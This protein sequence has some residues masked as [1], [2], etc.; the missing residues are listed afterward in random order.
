MNLKSIVGV[1]GGK[2]W[3]GSAK[4]GGGQPTAEHTLAE[5]FKGA[6]DMDVSDMVRLIW[7]GGWDS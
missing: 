3:G 2:Y 7:E 1:L 4:G 6:G 5:R